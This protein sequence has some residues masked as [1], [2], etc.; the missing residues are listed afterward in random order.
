MLLL[1]FFS[2]SFGVFLDTLQ[3]GLQMVSLILTRYLQMTNDDRG[4][5]KDIDMMDFIRKMDITGLSWNWFYC[6]RIE[7][8]WESFCVSYD[9]A[10]NVDTVSATEIELRFGLNR[11]AKTGEVIH[12]SMG[13]LLDIKF[14]IFE[15]L[16][17]TITRK[18]HA[19]E[20]A[21]QQCVFFC[22]VYYQQVLRFFGIN[23]LIFHPM[24]AYVGLSAYFGSAA[25]VNKID[26][27]RSN[28]SAGSSNSG[29]DFWTS[30]N[31]NYP[32]IPPVREII[33]LTVAGAA[34]TSSA[35]SYA[36]Y[37]LGRDQEIQSRCRQL[38]RERV[39]D[40]SEEITY[41]VAKDLDVAKKIF[42]ETM[43]LHPIIPLISKKL[44]FVWLWIS[45][46][47]FFWLCPQ[48]MKWIGEE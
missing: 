43:R 3:Q 7:M 30:L 17:G 31:E 11:S 15:A 39:G 42:Y 22:S 34:T 36:I 13:L 20:T 14:E 37:E 1:F 5:M 21:S 23:Y 41:E 24:E 25:I 28:A 45:F 46:G 35:L 18:G 19:F 8:L 38:I 2:V 6:C 4:E 16:F 9:W 29:N 33:T 40:A 44:T 48:V 26:Q 27:L 10:T 32:A 12:G 47:F